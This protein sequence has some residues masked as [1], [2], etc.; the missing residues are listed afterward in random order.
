MHRLVSQA[1]IREQQHGPDL[2]NGEPALV[3]HLFQIHAR[4][5]VTQP[6]PPAN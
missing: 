1:F 6:A 2:G 3:S 5:Q 4:C